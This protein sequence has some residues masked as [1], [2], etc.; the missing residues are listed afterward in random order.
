L[1]G[2][3][4]DSDEI[5]LKMPVGELHTQTFRTATREILGAAALYSAIVPRRKTDKKIVVAASW[6]SAVVASSLSL[7]DAPFLLGRVLPVGSS[8]H[9][10]TTKVASFPDGSG[11]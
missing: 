1:R 3:K 11:I 7:R 8:Q 9:A 6:R 5:R 10:K 2:R 4:T